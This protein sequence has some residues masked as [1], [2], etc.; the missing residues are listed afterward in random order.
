MLNKIAFPWQALASCDGFISFLDNLLATDGLLPEEKAVR[1]PLLLALSSLLEGKIV[2]MDYWTYHFRDPHF[3]ILLL[4]TIELPIIFEIPTVK[5]CHNSRFG[6]HCKYCPFTAVNFRG[7][8][9]YWDFWNCMWTPIQYGRDWFWNVP[10]LASCCEPG[11][12][13]PS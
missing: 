1:M 3:E 10:S 12:R 13:W 4:W 9:F 7:G 8:S 6:F 5:S 11:H 2:T